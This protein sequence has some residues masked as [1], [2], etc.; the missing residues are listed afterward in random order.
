MLIADFAFA[1]KAAVS[2]QQ[3]F[4]TVA[5]ISGW[6]AKINT[7][8]SFVNPLNTTQEIVCIVTYNGQ[9]RL[10]TGTGYAKTNVRGNVATVVN[11]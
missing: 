4:E 7:A 11:F 1:P 6:R 8:Y 3:D 9:V 5:T 2:A 10:Y